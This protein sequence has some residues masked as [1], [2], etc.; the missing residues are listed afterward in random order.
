[1][2]ANLSVI[3][4]VYGAERTIERCAESLF[5]QT[6]DNIEY[7]FVNDCTLDRSIAVLQSVIDRYPARRPQVKIVDMPVNSRQAA[8]RNAGL[9]HATGEYVIHCDPDDWVDSRL[10]KTMFDTAIRENLDIVA[11]DYII[12]NENNNAIHVKLPKVKNPME[13]LNCRQYYILS[14]CVHMVRRNIITDNALSF[15]PDINCS[16]DVGFMSRVFAVSDCIGHISEDYSYHYY[17]NE[18][19]ITNGL[20]RPEIVEQR[21]ECLRLIDEFMIARGMDYRNMSMLLR[22]K[23]DIKNLYLKNESLDKW[24]K[25]FPEVCEWECRQPESSIIYKTAYYLSHKVGTWPMRILLGIH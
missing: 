21:I 14:L 20:D 1:M 17:K 24:V 15:F 2:S 23:R 7:V 22:L 25:L 13:V 19:S 8:A 9:S 16:E 6:L 5:S 11:C 3:I 10:Y 12:E 18:Q 4:P